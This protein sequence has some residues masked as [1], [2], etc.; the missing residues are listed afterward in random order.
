M[1]STSPCGRILRPAT[2]VLGALFTSQVAA[3]IWPLPETTAYLS[4]DRYWRL[5]VIPRELESQLA[6][7]RD[8]VDG[9]EPAGA[10]SG[11]QQRQGQWRV[12]WDKPLL[13]EVSPADAVVS[14]SGQAVT[15]DNWHSLGYGLDVVVIYDA[16]GNVVR[17]MALDDFMP[18]QYIHTL[19]RSSSSIHWGGEHCITAFGERVVLRVAMPSLG[20]RAGPQYVEVP[21]E[22]ASGRVIGPR[23]GVWIVA[24]ARAWIVDTLDRL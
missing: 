4:A 5:T 3:D 21:V 14:R 22:L 12:V 15:F 24:I 11:N 1:N 20:R 23:P 10:A 2:L 13:N 7:F 8:K 18:E 16:Q 19:F 6:Y 17:A 9:R